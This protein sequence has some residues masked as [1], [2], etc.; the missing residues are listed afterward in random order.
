MNLCTAMEEE[1]WYRVR[2]ALA[3]RQCCSCSSGSNTSGC[4]PLLAGPSAVQGFD[5]PLCNRTAGPP[6]RT[7]FVYEVD[8]EA[9]DLAGT[10]DF[11]EVSQ[12]GAVFGCPA[13]QR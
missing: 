11:L 6:Y 1:T 5:D 2:T 4:Y 7:T 9:Y 13:H 3:V 10:R 8:G 12:H